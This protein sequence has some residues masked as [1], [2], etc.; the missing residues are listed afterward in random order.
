MLTS[1]AFF[2]R[3]RKLGFGVEEAGKKDKQEGPK[4]DKNPNWKFHTI[5]KSLVT[6]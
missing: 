6:T 2:P 3:K 5:L 1:H 4:L